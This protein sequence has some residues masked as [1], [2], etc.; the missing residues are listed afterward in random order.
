L[1]VCCFSQVFAS[2]VDS[3]VVYVVCEAS[4][5]N[6]YDFSVHRQ[7]GVFGGRADRPVAGSVE[8]ITSLYGEP[9]VFAESVVVGG[10]NDGVGRL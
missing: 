3:V 1:C 8:T 5:A 6:V 7:D 2:I 4:F 10:V 9:F